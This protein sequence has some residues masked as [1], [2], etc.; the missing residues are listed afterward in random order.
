MS[1][2]DVLLHLHLHHPLEGP[3]HGLVLVHVDFDDLGQDHLHLHLV[4]A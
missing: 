4:G 2:V 1:C 3:A